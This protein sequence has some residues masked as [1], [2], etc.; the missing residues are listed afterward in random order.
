MKK[1][2]F[3]QDFGI[4]SQSFGKGEI[5]EGEPKNGAI[6]VLFFD[7]GGVQGVEIPAQYVQEYTGTKQAGQID[8]V[9]PTGLKVTVKSKYLTIA[10][11]AIAIAFIWYNFLRK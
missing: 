5:V 4:G 7:G 9:T 2:I 11:V 8:V 10:L 1:Y 6:E 3:N